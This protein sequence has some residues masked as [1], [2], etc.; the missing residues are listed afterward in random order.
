MSKGNRWATNG[1]EYTEAECEII[2]AGKYLEIAELMKQLPGRSKSS[3]SGKRRWLASEYRI[4][5]FTRGEDEEIKI[6][7]KRVGLYG[8]RRLMP[9]RTID[10]IKNRAHQL[11]VDLFKKTEAPLNIVGEPLAD[12]IRD[13]AREAGIAMRALDRE[14]GT[15]GYFTNVAALRAKRG[16]GPYMPAILKALEFFEAELVTTPDGVTTIDWKDEDNGTL[17][18]RTDHAVSWLLG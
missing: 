12:A 7:G 4:I 18:Q 2:R 9:H 6:V 17:E 1:K 16:S 8:I 14:L 15:G 11:R 5:P 10:H 13:R 3:V